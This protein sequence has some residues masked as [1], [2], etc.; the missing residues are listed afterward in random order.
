[1]YMDEIPT[2][3]VIYPVKINGEHVGA[4][5]I[6]FSMDTVNATAS[7][8]MY[9]IGMMGAVIV[10]LLSAI[11]FRGSRYAIRVINRI[12]D[13]MNQMAQGDFVI[14]DSDYIKTSNDE[15]G[16]ITQ[17]VGTMKASVRTVLESVIDRSQALATQSE[18][19]TSTTHQ[20]AAAADQVARA[21][22]DIARGAAV[23]ASDT[24]L[25]YNA[26]RELSEIVDNNTVQI[27]NLQKSASMV[28]VLK[29]EGLELIGDLVEKTQESTQASGEVQQIIGDTNESA[30]VIAAANERIKNIASQTN[31][32]ALNASIEAAR[33]GEAGRGFSVVA[34]A[35]RKLAEESNGFADEIGRVTADLTSKTSKAVLTM[36]EVSQSVKEQ[37][38]SVNSTSEKFNGIAQVL[39]D[40]EKS[41]SVVN[42]SGDNMNFHNT[43]L[44]K[45]IENL[46]AISQESAASSEEVSASME[47]QS[48]AITQISN[49]SDELAN[50][51]E[52]LNNLISAFRI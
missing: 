17:A 39:E 6:G 49:A 46:A 5:N 40:M 3:D 12:R 22:E 28:N 47:E 30:V 32:L 44:S 45:M 13:Q 19:L 51:A 23:Q 37:E 27:S 21:V 1:M 38:K 52:K 24:E 41:M 11:L 2:Y 8:T 10:I 36:E 34:E 42:A 26:V 25:G 14:R 48:A 33:A 16:E 4:I 7:K 29:E 18:E 43:N 35:I 9:T 15:L 20:S 31:L 50:I